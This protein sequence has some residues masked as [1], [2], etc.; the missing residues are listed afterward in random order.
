MEILQDKRLWIVLAAVLVLL[1]AANSAGWLGGG[2][3]ETAVQEQAT[4]GEQTT[5][6]EQTI[7]Q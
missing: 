3:P 5:G 7:G 6:S 2:E 1:F 4:S